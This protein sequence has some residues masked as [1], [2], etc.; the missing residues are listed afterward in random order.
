MKVQYAYFTKCLYDRVWEGDQKLFYRDQRDSRFSRILET[1]FSF[2]LLVL[3]LEPFQFHFQFSKKS[4]GNSFFTFHFSKK[5]KA[6]HISLFFSR[7]KRVKSGAGYNLTSIFVPN[8]ISKNCQ[9][10]SKHQP[11]NIGQISISKS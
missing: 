10:S 8:C 5:V 1:F 9:I 4:E 6:V 3:D 2:S 7:E 11:Q